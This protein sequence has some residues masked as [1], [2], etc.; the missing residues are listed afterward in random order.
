MD[1]AMNNIFRKRETK[2]KNFRCMFHSLKNTCLDLTEELIEITAG[3][4]CAVNTEVIRIS[5]TT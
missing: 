5:M 4:T 1:R 2:V 3:K